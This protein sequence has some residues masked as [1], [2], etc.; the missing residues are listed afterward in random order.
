MVENLVLRTA[1]LIS[2]THSNTRVE[3]TNH[4]IL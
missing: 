1:F 3:I 2:A 4:N